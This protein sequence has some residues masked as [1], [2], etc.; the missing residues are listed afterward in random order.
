MYDIIMFNPA[1]LYQYER[2]YG[3]ASNLDLIPETKAS[4]N[5]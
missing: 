4:T 5:G 2:L 1:S 3:Q